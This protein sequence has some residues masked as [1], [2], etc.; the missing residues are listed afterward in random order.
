MKVNH[1]KYAAAVEYYRDRPEFFEQR[2]MQIPESGCHV[3]MASVDESGYAR[4]SATSMTN[5]NVLVHRLMWLL[6]G[7]SIEDGKW[8]DH[9]CRVRCCVNV[10]HL[11]P[12]THLVN[13]RRGNVVK[14]R[15]THCPLG[16]EY[17]KENIRLFPNKWGRITRSCKLCRPIHKHLSYQRKRLRQMEASA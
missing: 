16:H 2:I 9:L 17:T 12:V 14:P 4:A 11:E 15:K 7:R 10:N 6:S 1:A 5:L 8:L 3:W 13:V